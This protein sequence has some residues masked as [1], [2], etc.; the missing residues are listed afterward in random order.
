MAGDCGALNAAEIRNTDTKVEARREAVKMKDVS[1]PPRPLPASPRYGRQQFSLRRNAPRSRLTSGR[2]STESPGPEARWCAAGLGTDCGTPFSPGNALSTL[3]CGSSCCSFSPLL[4][5]SHSSARRSRYRLPPQRRGQIIHRVSLSK[6]S[7]K[8]S[9]LF[10]C[11]IDVHVDNITH[12][13]EW[14][15]DVI[16]VIF[17]RFCVYTVTTIIIMLCVYY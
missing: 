16:N 11:N 2:Y 12:N 15:F 1:P 14:I 6:L 3:C 8:T 9:L 4:P 7:F 17:P 13:K 5:Q 10:I